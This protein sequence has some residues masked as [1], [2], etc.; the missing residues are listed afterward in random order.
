[1]VF[2]RVA[3]GSLENSP[4]CCA[5]VRNLLPG[6]LGK[7]VYKRQVSI[8]RKLHIDIVLR[9]T[10]LKIINFLD[11]ISVSYTHLIPNTIVFLSIA[12]TYFFCPSVFVLIG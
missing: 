3:A 2:Y 11:H 5:G 7:D 4:I 10:T 8:N 1:M 9:H 6:R 12:S